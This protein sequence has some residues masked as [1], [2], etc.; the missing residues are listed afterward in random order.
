M[1]III[2]IWKGYPAGGY[3]LDDGMDACR[4][5]SFSCIIDAKEDDRRRTIMTTIMTIFTGG[6]IGSRNTGGAIQVNDSGS[7][8][9]I[10]KYTASPLKRDVRL[11]TAQP[12]NILS[13]NLVPGDWDKLIQA[14]GS[15]DF[16]QYA[17]IIVTH[18][19]DTL[20]YTAA[21]LSFVFAHTPV[22]I[23]LVASGN[24]LD[25]PRSN[26]LS[27]FA[28]AVDY[29]LGGQPPGV[30]VIYRNDRGESVV[31]LGTRISQALP[32]TDQFD[33]PYGVPYGV[34]EDGVFKPD[35]HRLNPSPEE[36][37][38][39]AKQPMQ[40]AD[41]LQLGSDVLYIRPFPGIDYSHYHFSSHAPKAVLHDL[42]HSGTASVSGQARHSVLAFAE[43]CREQGVDLYLCPLKDGSGALYASSLK[44]IEAGVTFIERMSVEAALMKLIFA[45]SRFDSRAQVR[46]YVLD[47]TVFFEHIGP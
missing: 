2:Y 6:T 22:P 12:L 45:Y 34:M 21:M 17:G 5:S 11:E 3:F 19:S 23:I 36:L 15:L 16:A 4:R 30:F 42:Y 31:Y 39:H 27:N 24:P 7:Y 29:I 1:I 32:F 43:Y 46:E 13:E 44:L 33:C 38:A 8:A 18:G 41:G 14:I 47:E 37:R 28:G 35:R 26:G 20:A 10:D 9:L 40:S 25:D